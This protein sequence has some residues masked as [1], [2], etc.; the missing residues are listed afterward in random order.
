MQCIRWIRYICLPLLFSKT[1]TS[2]NYIKLHGE[3]GPS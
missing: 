2:P 1:E 3:H